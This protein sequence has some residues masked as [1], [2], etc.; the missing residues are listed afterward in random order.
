MI[1]DFLRFSAHACGAGNRAAFDLNRAAF[2]AAF[3][4]CRNGFLEVRRRH[5][6]IGP[7][8][9]FGRVPEPGANGAEVLDV[10]RDN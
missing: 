5:E 6:Q 7:L 1:C 9:N 3:L 2:R 10:G 4:R 8:G